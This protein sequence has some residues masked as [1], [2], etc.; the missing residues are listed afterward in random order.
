MEDHPSQND[1]Y[2][3]VLADLRAQRDRIDTAIAAL[4]ALRGS[5]GT[6]PKPTTSS[7]EPAE[8]AGAGMSPGLLL[9]MSIADATIKVLNLRKRKMTNS[10]ILADLKAGGL[11]LTS[12]DPSNV[13]NS[14]LNR[15]FQSVGDVVR[16]ERGTWGL[17]TWYPGRNFSKTKATSAEK[18]A[19]EQIGVFDV[20]ID[21]EG[22]HREEHDD[23]SS[24]V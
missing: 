19:M 13:V 18:S 8:V 14:V 21:V 12:K 16:V 22:D 23:T 4:S 6:S 5:S 9:G 1:P 20:P 10:E 3:V 15:R 7:V 2:D 17:K 11:V 24:L